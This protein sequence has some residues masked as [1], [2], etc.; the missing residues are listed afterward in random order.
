M[1]LS[2][3]TRRAS[4]SRCSAARQRGVSPSGQGF[5]AP[6]QNGS[7]RL[8]ISQILLPRSVPNRHLQG[9]LRTKR[10]L[11]ASVPNPSQKCRAMPKLGATCSRSA[12]RRAAAAIASR[13]AAN[14]NQM[15]LPFPSPMMSEALREK[16][17][18]VRSAH[19]P[20]RRRTSFDFL[21]LDGAVRDAIAAAGLVPGRAHSAE[22]SA[23]ATTALAPPSDQAISM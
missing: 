2:R 17:L 8:L 23:K 22:L 19:Q 15:T 14:D 13:P 10:F 6:I 11:R 9:A 21:A 5:A 18:C 1:L 16:S 20:Y 7:T 12:S 4:S 3:H